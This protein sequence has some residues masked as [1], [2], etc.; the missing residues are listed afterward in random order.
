M[1]HVL[2]ETFVRDLSERPPPARR[3]EYRDAAFASVDGQ[4]VLR[5]ET[6]GR[7]VWSFV[8]Y[9]PGGVR[10]GKRPRRRL[11]IGRYPR[12]DLAKA[13]L[14]A[15]EWSDAVD[16]G[17][18]PAAARHGERTFA[19]LWKEY[20]ERHAKPRK[21]SWR[22]DEWFAKRHI[23]DWREDRYGPTFG[24]R[25]VRDIGRREIVRL[26]DSI[27]DAGSPRSANMVK[28]LLSGIFRFGADRGWLAQSP[29]LGMRQPADTPARDRQLSEEEIVAF[30]NACRAREG[31]RRTCALPLILVTAQ[32]PGEVLTV[33]VAEVDLERARWT[34]PAT[35]TKNGRAN[36]VPLSSLAVEL[37]AEALASPVSE[38]R[39]F[40]KGAPPEHRNPTFYANDVDPVRKAMAKEPERE[41]SRWTPHDLR[42]T[43]Y[44]GMTSVG[45]PRVPV[46][47][48]VVNH[49]IAGVAATYDVYDYL[50]EKTDALNRWGLHLLRL[51][52]GRVNDNVAHLVR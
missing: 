17:L 37:F 3:M 34:I 52:E 36:L 30:W 43:A 13:R 19:D 2:T 41:V 6:S 16:A 1:P 49:A 12:I 8:Y 21:R 51:T 28:S 39:P 32:R 24:E 31:V 46:V 42:R 14:V 44:S 47:E 4:L 25:P 11:R 27:V 5:H 35:K 7:L 33:E 45:L 10:D 9:V 18:D 40:L 48:A 26:L 23:L 20:L 50:P 29:M 38:R 22:D 15:G